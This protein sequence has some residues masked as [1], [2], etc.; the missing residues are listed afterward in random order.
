MKC[1][2]VDLSWKKRGFSRGE[3]LLQH[4]ISLLRSFNSRMNH[5]IDYM[6]RLRWQEIGV[7]GY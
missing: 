6:R 3:K 5:T 1:G 4:S 7:Y 2:Q